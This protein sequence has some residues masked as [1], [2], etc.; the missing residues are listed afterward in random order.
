MTAMQDSLADLLWPLPPYLRPDFEV[1]A[2]K[3]W[4]KRFWIHLLNIYSP[5]GNFLE[6]WLSGVIDS[7]NLPI[8]LLGDFNINLLGRDPPLPPR[9]RQLMD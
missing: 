7:Y 4:L 3:V 2:V 1:L 9:I 8:I 6:E 5:S